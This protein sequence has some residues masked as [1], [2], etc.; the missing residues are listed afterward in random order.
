M[1]LYKKEQYLHRSVTER[2]TWQWSSINKTFIHFT[3]T[4]DKYALTISSRKTKI[5]LTNLCHTRTFVSLSAR[6]KQSS[7][8]CLPFCLITGAVSGQSSLIQ[9]ESFCQRRI[10]TSLFLSWNYLGSFYS[11]VNWL[12]SCPD[13]FT[14]TGA[15]CCCSVTNM[16]HL[17][18]EKKVKK[19]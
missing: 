11:L 4:W 16:K 12:E 7:L 19:L 2:W 13:L 3:R 5:H 8:L 6:L 1:G 14:Q 10:F 18:K 15:A 17:Q 9:T